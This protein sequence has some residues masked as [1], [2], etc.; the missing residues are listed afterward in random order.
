MSYPEQQPGDG[1]L[2]QFFGKAHV[3]V[4]LGVH[5]ARVHSIHR[6][7]VAGGLDLLMEVIGE[8]ELRQFASGVRGM[9]AVMLP[10]EQCRERRIT[11][12]Y[13]SKITVQTPDETSNR[14]ITCFQTNHECERALT[15]CGSP[16]AVDQTRGGPRN[17]C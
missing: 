5:H 15:C 7:R 16:A 12:L 10:S 9:W 14:S 2:G 1:F 11:E 13:D 6:E 17:R 4:Q 3:A 8:Q